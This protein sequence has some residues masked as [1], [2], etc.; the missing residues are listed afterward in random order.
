[1]EIN[2]PHNVKSKTRK[3]NFEIIYTVCKDKLF[4]SI[5]CVN[6]GNNKLNLF[7]EGVN[8]EWRKLKWGVKAKRR[9]IRP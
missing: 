4:V 7:L 1:M 3:P 9:K 8:E 6:V 5:K 2:Q